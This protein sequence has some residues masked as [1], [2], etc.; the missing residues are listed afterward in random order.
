VLA[1]YLPRG[2]RL[3]GLDV[4]PAFVGNARRRKYTHQSGVAMDVTFGVQSV[5]ETFRDAEGR[6]ITD[7]SVDLV[8]ASGAV[9]C[10]FD[11]EASGKL[12][13]EV[14]RVL[15]PGGLAMIDSGLPGTHTGQLV[16][17]FGEHGFEVCRKTRS[18][19]LDPYTQVCFRRR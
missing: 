10:H 16:R 5:L 1:C 14:R 9:G 15:Q 13:A 11:E 2:S 7:G 6:A 4:S 8:N 3:L 17:I 18:C 12:A 19:L